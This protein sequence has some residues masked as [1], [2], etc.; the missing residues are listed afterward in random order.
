MRGAVYAEMV[1]KDFKEIERLEGAREVVEGFWKDGM[2]RVDEV[3]E[4]VGGKILIERQIE[5]IRKGLKEVEKEK[6]KEPKIG[7]KRKGK[8]KAKVTDGGI[9]GGE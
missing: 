8:A 6:E 5:A 9:D 3:V 4:R 2:G 1:E 7:E